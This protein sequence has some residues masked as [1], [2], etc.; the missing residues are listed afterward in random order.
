MGGTTS[1]PPA[2]PTAD[3]AGCAGSGTTTRR[4]RRTGGAAGRRP[5]TRRSS[6]SAPA[7]SGLAAARQLTRR[8]STP[9]CSRRATG[10]AAAPRAATTDGGAPVELGGQWVGPTQNRMYELVAELGLETFPTY[11]DGRARG[12]RSAARRAAWPPQRGAVPKLNPFALADLAQGLA[13]FARARRQDPPRRAVARSPPPASSTARPSRPGSARNLRTSSG[14][15][16]FR[17]ACE[18]VFSAESTDLSALHALFYAHSGH[19]PRD[20][21]VGR[22]GRP[23]GPHRRRLDP[24]QPSAW[25]KPWATG[26]RL[27]RPVRRID[28]GDRRGAWSRPGTARHVTRPAR[29]SSPSP[30]PRRTARVLPGAAV[31]ARPA[32]PAAAGRFGDQALRGLRRAVLAGRRPHR[33]GRVGRSG[34]VKVTFDNSP[35]AGSPGMHRWGS[36]RPTTAASGPAVRWTSGADAA[37]DCFVRYFGP[38]AASPTS[39]T[40]SATGWPRSSP[41]GATAPTSRP[42]SGPPTATALAEPVGPIHWAGAECS[43]VWNGYMEGAVRSGERTAADVALLLG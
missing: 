21:A 10:S 27:G 6:W 25:P 35:P 29:S 31:V 1:R 30:H 24:H 41:A 11:N 43:P 8:V 40:W 19:R 39:S 9:S 36:W 32:H 7:S 15:A 38:K 18:A 4:R 2:C 28:H 33:P 5:T 20:A 14:R 22:P 34:P 37:V 16:Y 42:A 3:R 26:V 23:A 13:R 17:I 12:R